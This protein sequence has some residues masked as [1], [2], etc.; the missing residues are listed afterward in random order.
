MAP[1]VKKKSY[2][3]PKTK[4]T[5]PEEI[6]KFEQAPQEIQFEHFMAMIKVREIALNAA[7]AML[8]GVDRLVVYKR[9]EEIEGWVTRRS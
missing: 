9:A 4:K 1:Q 5:A 7:I 3:K 2:Y 6:Q 8:P